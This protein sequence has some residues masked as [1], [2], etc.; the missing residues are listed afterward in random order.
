MKYIWTFLRV[1]TKRLKVRG[2]G[3]KDVTLLPPFIEHRETWQLDFC[4]T[5]RLVKVSAPFYLFILLSIIMMT[6]QAVT[7]KNI[8]HAYDSGN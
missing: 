6:S 7:T 1:R 2:D 3:V 4:V 5:E 8:R